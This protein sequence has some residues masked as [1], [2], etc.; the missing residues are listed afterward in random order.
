MNR[1]RRI[2]VLLGVLASPVGFAQK[3][4]IIDELTTP[5]TTLGRWD[6][7]IDW[8]TRTAWLAE[9]LAVAPDKNGRSFKSDWSANVLTPEVKS[10][11]DEL[12]AKAQEYSAAGND[13]E[14]KRVIAEA[15]P[16]LSDQ[17]HQAFMVTSYWT[18]Q[19]AVQTHL[20]LLKPW[21]DRASVEDRK[22]LEERVA[23]SRDLLARDYEQQLREKT[24]DDSRFRQLGENSARAVDLLNSER[25]RLV[26]AQASLPNP[27]PVA[28]RTRTADCPEAAAPIEGREKPGLGANFPSSE[29]YYPL[30]SKRLGITGTVTVRVVLSETG[31]V[32]AAEVTGT[33]GARELDEG[34]LALALEGRYTP[35]SSGGKAVPGILAFR[36]K[37]EQ[38]VGPPPPL[39]DVPPR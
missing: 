36:V 14:L 28:P 24:Y 23:V 5:T 27:L 15:S 37:F 12:R 17:M 29:D 1:L 3:L 7:T 26:S 11:L 33:S 18:L 10:R 35:G 4:P 2:L 6:E 21:V 31:C 39:S 13:A 19:V 38:P 16:I 8:I 20:S 9:T 22:A 34:A 32:Q 25:L 30:Q